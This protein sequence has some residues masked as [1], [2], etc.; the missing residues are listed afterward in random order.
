MNG[1]GVQGQ[2]QN[3]C[4]GGLNQTGALQGAPVWISGNVETSASGN[5]S[6]LACIRGAQ[7]T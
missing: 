6:P 4:P 2:G 3:S 7:M 5:C 1:V